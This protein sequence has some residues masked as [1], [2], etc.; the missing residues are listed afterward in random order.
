MS[1]YA[2]S[3]LQAVNTI[4][5]A[6]GETPVSSLETESGVDVEMAEATLDQVNREVQNIGW[7]FNSGLTTFSP[8]SSGKIQLPA[9]VLRF[10]SPGR[11]VGGGA[12]H[13][14]AGTRLV[15]R[16]GYLYNRTD[17]TDTFASPV[18]L[19]VVEYVDWSDL[20]EAART[21]ITLKAARRYADRT[22]GDAALSQ[23]TRQDEQE[24]AFAVRKEE[25][26]TGNRRI[27]DTHTEVG[28]DYGSPIDFY[29][30]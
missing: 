9:T 21:Y 10:S 11:G 18:T 4:L 14:G 27:F 8:D 12:N 5:R 29:P 25:T 26:A 19:E 2:S 13:P 28:V 24:A 22:L 23:Y 20:P 6:V 1:L 7:E 17:E 3:R 15:T 16:S 30:G